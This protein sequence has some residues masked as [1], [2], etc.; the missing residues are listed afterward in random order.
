LLD[1]WH[2]QRSCNIARHLFEPPKT[3]YAKKEEA[4]ND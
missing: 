1:P 3:Y 4:K 2:P